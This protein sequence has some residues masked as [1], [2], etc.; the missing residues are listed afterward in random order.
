MGEPYLSGFDPGEI[1]NDLGNV[2]LELIEDLDGGEMYQRYGKA[3][4]NV[5]QPA[6]SLHIA[7]ARVPLAKR[8]GK[9]G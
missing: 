4:S 8:P 5:L 1:E 7:L 9:G 3:G 2:G 6:G